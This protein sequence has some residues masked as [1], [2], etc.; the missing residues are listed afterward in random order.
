LAYL[1]TCNVLLLQSGL[2]NI[3]EAIQIIAGATSLDFLTN[4]YF[5]VDDDL[6]NKVCLKSKN[7]DLNNNLQ[8]V[9]YICANKE[10]KNGKKSTG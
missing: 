5:T 4:S 1:N 7:R 8:N 10:T 2:R 6:N 9:Y 3:S